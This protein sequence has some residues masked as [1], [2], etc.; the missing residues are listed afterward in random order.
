MQRMNGKRH[1]GWATLDA[2]LAL[3]LWSTLGL[4]L[5]WQTRSLWV[6][7]RALWQQTAA[8]EWQA[9]LFERLRLARSATPVVLSWGQSFQGGDCVQND[10]DPNAWRN[11]LLADWQTRMRLDLPQ[12][13][14]WLAPWS[15]NTQ[16]Q[17]LG[18]RW[19]ERGVQMQN[20]PVNGETCP[21]DWRCLVTL[22][23]P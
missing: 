11:S 2:L 1:T 17:V 23:W 14:A 13:Q 7:Q 20:L 18:L 5:V 21:A 22:G 19:P 3:G 15:G 9:D 10:C 16:V 8:A 12:A 4:G 6:A